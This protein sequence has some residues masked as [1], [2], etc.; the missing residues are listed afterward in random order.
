MMLYFVATALLYFYSYGVLCKY[1]PKEA[2]QVALM[3]TFWYL[4][5]SKYSYLGW[6]VLGHYAPLFRGSHYRWVFEFAR[7]NVI[8]AFGVLIYQLL[9]LL[10]H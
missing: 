4:S 10:E 1:H 5:K 2:E 8:V 7:L 9:S 3:D 6:L